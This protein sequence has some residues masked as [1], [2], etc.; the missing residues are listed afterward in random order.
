[1]FVSVELVCAG[2]NQKRTCKKLK[3]LKVLYCYE[4]INQAC[5]RWRRSYRFV[6]RCLTGKIVIINAPLPTQLSSTTLRH[7]ISENLATI[8]SL[9]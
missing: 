4:P 5:P 2:R 6:S 9:S 3:L 8:F 1:M 7:D